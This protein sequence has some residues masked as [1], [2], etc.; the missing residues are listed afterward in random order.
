M[1]DECVNP[2]IV[3][4][5]SQFDSDL[6][7]SQACGT[8]GSIVGRSVSTTNDSF[9]SQLS[10]IVRPDLNNRTVECATNNGSV[11][12]RKQIAIT[13]TFGFHAINYSINMLIHPP[14]NRSETPSPPKQHHNF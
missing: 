10:F 9:T 12:G 14:S 11:V 6:V 5:H 7:V 13:S 3:L 1:F 2:R 8:F 4:R